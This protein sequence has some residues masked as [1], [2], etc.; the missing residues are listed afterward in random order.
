MFVLIK[1]AE[2]YSPS[3]QGKKDLLIAGGKIVA[4]ENEIQEAHIYGNYKIIEA[5]GRLAV[6]GFVDTHQHFIGGGGEGSFK[7]RTP[8]LTLTMQTLNGVTTAMGLLGTDSMT[9]HV[10]SLYGKTMAFREEGISAYMITGSYFIPSP[11]ITGSV[12]KDITF[13]EPVVGVKLAISDHRGAYTTV[14]NIGELVAQV[15]VAGLLSGKA[16]IITLHTG[17]GKN[18]L[19]QIFELLEK[20]D[21][22]AER[23]VPTHINRADIWD[24]AV[25]LAKMGAIIDGTAISSSD[26]GKNKI[27]CAN[28]TK[29]SIEQGIADNFTFSSDAGGSLPVWDES[30]LNIIG[31]GVGTPSSLLDEVKRGIY[32]ESLTLPEILKPI[33]VNAARQ[34]GL[35]DSKGKIETG[36][37]ADIL[38]LDAE[39]LDITHTI[40]NGV[41]M[42]ENG[43]AIVKGTFE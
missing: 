10:E 24:D 28:A 19:N 43:K 42:V 25:R 18:K 13:L 2:L 12:D 40:A 22:Q 5:K 17:S 9:R 34:L 14:D 26:G 41:V 16:G 3:S 8:E 15:R 30:R 27:T 4:I 39:S 6:P 31:I 35:S 36:F 7:T 1:G 29:R 20:T 11:T 33:T 23:F 37:D 38:L 21:Y 32:E